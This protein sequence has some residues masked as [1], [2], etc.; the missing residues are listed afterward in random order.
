[1]INFSWFQ[2]KTKHPF[3]L[4][5]VV[6]GGIAL[7]ALTLALYF[8]TRVG[9]LNWQVLNLRRQGNGQSA[10]VEAV[11]DLVSRV[12]RHMVLPEDE[13]PTI[14]TVT[15]PALLKDQPFFAR[16]KAG[17]KVLIY[18]K[19]KKAILYDPTADKIIDVGPVGIKAGE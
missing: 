4:I 5:I 7:V 1:M 16:A 11:R 9:E 10:S 17:F 18:P 12:G 14:A 6:V 13:T 15:D 19:A 2:S 3:A 8:F